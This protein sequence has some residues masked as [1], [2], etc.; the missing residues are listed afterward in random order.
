VL[1]GL[2]LTLLAALSFLVASCGKA[3]PSSGG[4]PINSIDDLTAGM[5]VGVQRGTTGAFYAEETLAPKGVEVVTF[6]KIPDMYNALEAGH[7]QAVLSDLP[8]SVDAVKHKPTLE[9]VQKIDSGEEFAFA[10]EKDNPSLR[11]AMNQ[12]L[13]NL[14]ADG[15]YATLFKKY[16]PDQ[17]LPPYVASATA[18]PFQGCP[19]VKTLAP[20]T[21]TVGTDFP[22]PPFEVFTADG[23]PAGFDIDLMTAVARQLCRT[24]RWVDAK[25]DT[26]F[27]TLS[28]GKLDA[29][30]SGVTGYAPQGSPSFAT[31]EARKRI[32]AFTRPYFSSL[33]SLTVKKGDQG[34]HGDDRR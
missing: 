21:L 9:V 29:V 11:E 5:R 12:A 30:A 25:Y 14:F 1:K 28:A 32:V 31:V 4:H 7:L 13:E 20:D 17:R 34:E 18:R 16:F 26:I 24:P 27:T 2:R 10:V 33:Q 3:P 22:Y 19:S 23:V 15:T 6:M 8:A